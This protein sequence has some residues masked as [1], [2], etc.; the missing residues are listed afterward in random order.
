[1]AER[2]L[3]LVDVNA[4]VALC[5]TSHQHHRPAHAFLAGVTGAWATCPV[6]ES[7]LFRLL[8]NPAVTGTPRSAGEVAAVVAGLQADPR[9]RFL[10][11]DSRLGEPLVDLNVLMGHQQVTD[12]HLVNL[13]APLA[14]YEF[15]FAG[16][17]PM[18]QALQELLMVNH[19]VPFEQIHF[20][21]FF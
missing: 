14:N 15:Y 21:R 20:D 4:L 8:L 13:A 9:W 19:R 12:L 7:A 11:D 5:L 17:P 3:T 1:M 6:T 2:R 16:P 18:T 10:P